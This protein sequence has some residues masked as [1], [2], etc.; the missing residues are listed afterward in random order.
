[1]EEESHEIKV[2]GP[3]RRENTKTA[4]RE[5]E[6][7]PLKESGGKSAVCLRIFLKKTSVQEGRDQPGG[8]LREMRMPK[9]E[10]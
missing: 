8:R 3:S 2:T 9:V 4:S 10:R 1:V 5:K 6:S 7:N